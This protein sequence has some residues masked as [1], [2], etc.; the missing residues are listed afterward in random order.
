MN[1]VNIRTDAQM[2]GWMGRWLKKKKK[3]EVC[4]R[5]VCLVG[6]FDTAHKSRQLDM[7]QQKGK[8]ETSRGLAKK[9]HKKGEGEGI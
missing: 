7:K 6:C 1:W 5:N 3:V 2:D 9:G 4:K 8:A